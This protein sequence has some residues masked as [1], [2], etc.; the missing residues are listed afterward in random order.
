VSA[1]KLQ[2]ITLKNGSNAEIW[3]IRAPD[4]TWQPRLRAFLNNPPVADGPALHEFLLANELPGFTVCYFTML[5]GSGEI[6]GCIF[7]TD[8]GTAGYINSTFV[9]RE[10]RQLGI[11][12]HLMD[13]LEHDLESR[14]GRVRFFTTRTGSPAVDMFTKVGYHEVWERGG[15]TGME[16]FYGD[17]TW[18]SYFGVPYDDLSIR[19]V[20]W[21]DWNAHRAMSWSRNDGAWHP[22][23]GNF[24]GLLR[25][26][27]ENRDIQWKGLFSSDGRM[28]GS[29]VVR[30]KDAWV[31]NQESVAVVDVYVHPTHSSRLND[32]LDDAL[33]ASGR[34]QTF[35][36]AASKDLIDA[37]SARG[38]A[39]ETSLRDDYNHHNPQAPDIRVYT[40]E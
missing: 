29:V 35:Q 15:R 24:V 19:H 25:D 20:A 33:P 34:F 40:R 27:V 36:N 14:G 32:L 8:G 6:M 9:T 1:E 22:L 21:G 18:E 7:T 3:L 11:G 10:Y 12:R 26:R 28:V 23:D 5:S 13:S 16:K 38:F 30:R 17:S 4:L 39:Q 31:E 2:D 37:F